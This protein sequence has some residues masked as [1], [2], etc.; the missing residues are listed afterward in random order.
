MLKFF[1]PSPTRLG[2]HPAYVSGPLVGT[3]TANA[4]TSIAVATPPGRVYLDRATVQALTAPVDA[5][6][7]FIATLKRRDVT[8]GVT[9]A[10]TAAT[11]L[12]VAGLANQKGI[13]LPLL[14]SLTEAQKTVN[15]GDVL[16]LDVANNSAAIDTQPIGFTV[17]VE[18][19]V[20][21]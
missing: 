7:T 4:T 8:T 3:L 21:S 11:N 6:G 1:R 18:V 15:A 2:T 9:I 10:L 12:I 16:F 14:A 20:L 19:L 5:D 17:T 13:S